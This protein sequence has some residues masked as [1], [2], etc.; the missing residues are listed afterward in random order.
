MSAKP[1]ILGALL[2]AAPLAARSEPLSGNQ[3]LALAPGSEFR[4]Y[5]QTQ[6]GFENHIWRFAPDG[7]VTAVATLSRNPGGLGWS[8]EFGDA[9]SWR[10]EGARLCVQW[11]AQ[12]GVFN[13]CYSVDAT[14]GSDQVRL[15]GPATWQGTFAR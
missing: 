6:R 14:S 10:I 1:I 7:R 4:G 12:L 9:G 13:G 5:I 2:A 3:L 15:I 11:Q 8:Q